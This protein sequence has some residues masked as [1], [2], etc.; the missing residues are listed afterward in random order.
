MSWLRFLEQGMQEVNFTYLCL[1]FNA[2]VILLLMLLSGHRELAEKITTSVVSGIKPLL[3]VFVKS[4]TRKKKKG[5]DVT[6]TDFDAYKLKGLL[7]TATVWKGTDNVELVQYVTTELDSYTN[8]IL[9]NK[10]SLERKTFSKLQN[11]KEL[12][13]PLSHQ[14]L[15]NLVKFSFQ[16]THHVTAVRE[17]PY[18][19]VSNAVSIITEGFTDQAVVFNPNEIEKGFALGLWEDK[20]FN[21][22]LRKP[23]L[24]QIC[25]SIIAEESVY[26]EANRYTLE[27]CGILTNGLD[28]IALRRERNRANKFTN[29]FYQCTDK[30]ETVKALVHFLTNCRENLHILLSADFDVSGQMFQRLAIC[31][32]G[33]GDESSDV[34]EEPSDASDGGGKMTPPPSN[35]ASTS[36]LSL[37]DVSFAEEYF[38]RS[39]L[40]LIIQCMK[41]LAY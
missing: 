8:K 28:F 6:G 24:A 39:P 33:P 10:D 21:I 41:S 30:E 27:M 7:F 12:V 34:D 37:R 38:A 11:E 25:T 2:N 36:Q 3:E 1:L 32:E 23:E 13:Q 22:P 16:D 35:H 19:S 20:G 18:G 29:L 4:E 26:E 17:R 31:K 14:L 15:K 40:S 5:S 9:R